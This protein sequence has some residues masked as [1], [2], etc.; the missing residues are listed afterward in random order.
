MAWKSM[1]SRV[2]WIRSSKKYGVGSC[3]P[4]DE[5]YTDAEVV[6]RLREWD[7]AGLTWKRQRVEI[8]AEHDAFMER[9]EAAISKRWRGGF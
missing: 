3:S 6:E 5:C 7:L 9:M 1:E 4:W 8:K 2:F